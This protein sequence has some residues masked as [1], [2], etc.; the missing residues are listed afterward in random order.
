MPFLAT[1]DIESKLL[2]EMSC[3]IMECRQPNKF[4]TGLAN[5]VILSFTAWGF[6]YVMTVW[7]F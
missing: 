6:I 7:M 5:G 1:D 4:F 2:T 3:R